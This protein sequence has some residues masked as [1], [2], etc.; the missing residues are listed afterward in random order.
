MA[1]A[2]PYVCNMFT[3]T[4][5][6]DEELKLERETAKVRSEMRQGLVVASWD[7]TY[8]FYKPLPKP[9]WFIVNFI[10]IKLFVLSS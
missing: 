8:Y 10:H 4:L 5:R 3:V 9:L 2:S 1:W 7:N 6:V